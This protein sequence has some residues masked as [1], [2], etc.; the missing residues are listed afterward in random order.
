VWF[1][2]WE[3]AEIDCSKVSPAVFGPM[4]FRHLRNRFRIGENACF[5][6]F[7]EVALAN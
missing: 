7:L 6:E 3:N 5:I 2:D 1:V 4:I